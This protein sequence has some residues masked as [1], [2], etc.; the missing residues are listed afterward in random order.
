MIS[1]V[2][3]Q[4]V[5]LILGLDFAEIKSRSGGE[6]SNEAL[7]P[8]YASELADLRAQ[9]R[10]RQSARDITEFNVTL[11]DVRFRAVTFSDVDEKPVWLLSRSETED[12]PLEKIGLPK[13]VITEV[14][15]PK[16]S[17]LILILGGF[18][19]GKTTTAASM[20]ASR[21]E[22][23]G[24]LG[25]SFE[26]PVE[27]KLNGVR[28][29]GRIVQVP[30]YGSYQGPLQA[31]L[32]SRAENFY[33]G[34]IRNAATAIEVLHYASNETPIFATLHADT[35][36]QG[37]LKFQAWC[38]AMDK[39]AEAINAMLAEAIAMI[40][41]QK[42]ETVVGIGGVT[43]RRLIPRSLILHTESGMSSVKAKIRKGD[44]AALGDEIHAQAS[45]G[46]YNT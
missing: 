32:R 20:F 35:I 18:G 5:D 29:R 10:A 26:D 36:E 42:L 2:D 43:S 11:R 34:E 23:F 12:M 38:R 33:V 46:A 21:V 39:S 9:C 45:R 6:R 8:E 14:L 31:G 28:G 1:L 25:M 40:V 19:D 7:G 24:G 15:R 37:L 30:V 22:K 4:F 13:A 41:H 3:K 44:F 16:L 27:C 17:G